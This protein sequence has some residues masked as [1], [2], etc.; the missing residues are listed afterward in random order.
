MSY[1]RISHI[2]SNYEFFMVYCWRGKKVSKNV[3]TMKTRVESSRVESKS[4]HKK[5]PTEMWP[6]SREFDYLVFLR[7]RPNQRWSLQFQ[8]YAVVVRYFPFS[9]ISNSINEP[10][11]SAT[12]SHTQI[13]VSE[14][15]TK[16]FI[17]IMVHKKEPQM[18]EETYFWFLSSDKTKHILHLAR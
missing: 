18:P 12:H 17:F 13:K 8:R 4:K 11:S 14:K 5:R 1:Y 15:N 10:S 3:R 16:V 6:S 9:S 7:I 2:L